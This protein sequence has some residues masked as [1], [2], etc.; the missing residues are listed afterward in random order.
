MEGQPVAPP[1]THPL[2]GSLGD[3][4]ERAR[5]SG[6]ACAPGD[7][8]GVF[9]M[10]GK[11]GRVIEAHMGSHDGV[12]VLGDDVNMFSYVF[13]EDVQDSAH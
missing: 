8:V 4:Q 9:W 11:V 12:P 3:T 2:Y 7:G 10:G 5:D 1:T 13:D 6:L